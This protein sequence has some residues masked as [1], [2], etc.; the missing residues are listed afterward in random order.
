MLSLIIIVLLLWAIFGRSNKQQNDTTPGSLSSHNQQ[1]VQFI[2]GYLPLAKTKGERSLLRR[3]LKDTVD[4]NIV[5]P[6]FV[7][8]LDRDEQYSAQPA[9]TQAPMVSDARA[10]PDVTISASHDI[11]VPRR[12]LDNT[13]LLLYFGAF[14]FVASMGLFVAFSGASGV[15]RTSGVLIVSLVLYFGGLWVHDQKQALKPAGLA[16]VGIGIATA[17][18]VG[19]AAYKY[20]PTSTQGL[21]WF[22][23]SLFCLVLYAHALVK[24]KAPLLNYI[25]IFTLLSLF[26][27]S[28]SIVNVPVYYYGWVMAALGIGLQALSMRGRVSSGF[29]ESSNTMSS[30]F[31]PLAVC[32]SLFMTPQ[33]GA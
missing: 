9:G 31:L 11:S 28:V 29:A 22:I 3:M 4:Q 24:L 18:L 20:I 15:V 17:P 19:V 2:A 14:L 8:A 5:D 13:S 12:Q 23:T 33:H 21:V 1:W 32:I 30:I 27:S 10:E 7:Q 6:E 25:L 26:E 16:F